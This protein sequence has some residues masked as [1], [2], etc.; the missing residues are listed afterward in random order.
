MSFP[1]ALIV[2]HIET[3]VLQ[4][5]ASIPIAMIGM[6]RMIMDAKE[7]NLIFF[8]YLF[9]FCRSKMGLRSP[10]AL[11]SGRNMNGNPLREE[12]EPLL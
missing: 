9:R 4:V 11:E 3:R 6:E 8:I 12:G 7:Q 2:S 1:V 10:F 5:K